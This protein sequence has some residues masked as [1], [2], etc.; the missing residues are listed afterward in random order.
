[1]PSDHAGR[2]NLRF[3]LHLSG[4]DHLRRYADLPRLLHLRR[5]R[6]LPRSANLRRRVR[7]DVCRLRYLPWNGN[8]LGLDDLPEPAYVPA[9][10]ADVAR[11]SDLRRHSNM[12]A[13]TDVL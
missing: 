13:G 6:D 10:L 11:F 2:T 9:E 5:F 4:V 3:Q 7:R 8:L 1:M 12:P